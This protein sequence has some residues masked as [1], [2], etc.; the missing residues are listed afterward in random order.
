MGNEEKTRR[1]EHEGQ[2]LKRDRVNEVYKE[3]QDKRMDE[4]KESKAR[5][6]RRNTAMDGRVRKT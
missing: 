6:E 1:K 3:G 5:E 2:E 4:S